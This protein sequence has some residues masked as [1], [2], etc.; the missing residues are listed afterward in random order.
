MWL[1]RTELRMG[2]F[3]LVTVTMQMQNSLHGEGRGGEGRGGQGRGGEGRRGEEAIRTMSL[4]MTRQLLGM[5]N[6]RDSLCR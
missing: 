4:H 2:P 3:L 5:Y 6:L 1:G